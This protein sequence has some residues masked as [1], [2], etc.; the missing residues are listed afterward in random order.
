MTGMNK[1]SVKV[2]KEW[3]APKLKKVGIEEI[4]A[5]KSTGTSFDGGGYPDDVSS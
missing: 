1:N 3:A 4:T 5:T 2:K